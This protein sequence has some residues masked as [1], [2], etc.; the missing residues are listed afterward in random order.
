MGLEAPVR[1]GDPPGWG[2]LWGWVLVIMYLGLVT[3]KEAVL[4]RREG[5]SYLFEDV[6]FFVA[7]D[8]VRDVVHGS[9]NTG[10]AVAF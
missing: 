7:A 4:Q 6:R 10:D 2:D 1:E 5:V 8:E 9:R 3:G